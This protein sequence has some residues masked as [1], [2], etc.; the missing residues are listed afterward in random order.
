MNKFFQIG[1]FVLDVVMSEGHKMSSRVTEFPVEEGSAFSD[2]IR[3]NPMMITCEGIVTNTPLPSNLAQQ[4]KIG[5]PLFSQPDTVSGGSTEP[6]VI[7]H[8]RSDEAYEYLRNIWLAGQPVTIRTSLGVFERMALEDLDIPRDPQ[9]GDALKFTASFKQ[10]QVISNERLKSSKTPGYG[11]KNRRGHQNG[12]PNVGARV[13][14]KRG[15]QPGGSV[16]YDTRYVEMRYNPKAKLTS[17]Y[18]VKNQP[19]NLAAMTFQTSKVPAGAP[20]TTEVAGFFSI[21]G[22]EENRPL[23]AREDFWLRKDLARDR[24]VAAQ[25][26]F[27]FDVYFAGLSD[28]ERD[29]ARRASSKASRGVIVDNPYDPDILRR[30]VQDPSR[31]QRSVMIDQGQG[32]DPL[33]RVSSKKP[34]NSS[35]LSQANN[36]FGTTS[37]L[38]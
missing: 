30:P 1:N 15:I 11:G 21:Y 22:K 6:A 10:I 16:I 32:S 8:L 25:D 4:S 17:W 35:G 37:L 14:W 36:N 33:S 12:D 24:T 13:L 2:N 19:I 29:A 31:L 34:L 28:D 9:T 23:S 3:P 38:P 20:A 5:K 18:Y 27:L 26:A 7:Q